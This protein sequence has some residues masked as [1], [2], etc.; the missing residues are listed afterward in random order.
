LLEARPGTGFNQ[1]GGALRGARELVRDHIPGSARQSGETGPLHV[2]RQ[3]FE[4]TSNA[5][6]EQLYAPCHPFI[7]LHFAI[8]L[9]EVIHLFVSP[10]RDSSPSGPRSLK[11][12]G[13]ESGRRSKIR[14]RGGERCSQ[15]PAALAA[16]S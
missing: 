7:L 4:L 10:P 12:G 13:P 14:L 6:I 2:G 5:I 9:I 3:G 11:G 8:F 16:M 1:R 15:A